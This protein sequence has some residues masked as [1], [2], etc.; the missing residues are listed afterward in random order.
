[1]NLSDFQTSDGLFTIAPFDHRG[2]L[3]KSLNL[4]L[5]DEKTKQIFLNLKTLF[6][7]ILS[8]HVSAV[9]TDPEYGLQTLGE[10]APDTGLFLSLEKSGYTDDHESMTEL[11]PNWGIDGV[12]KNNAGAKLLVYCNPGSATIQAKYDLIKKLSDEAKQKEVVF[13]VEPVLY[14]LPT[15]LPGGAWKEWDEAWIEA[16]LD[17]CQNI[18]PY[19]DILK[20][21]YPGSAEACASVTRMHPNWILLSRGVE[22]DDFARLLKDS[23]QH[24]CRGFA[25]GRAVW[26]ELTKIDPKGWEKFLEKTSVKRLVELTK[27]LRDNVPAH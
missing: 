9:L 6:M 20:V 27:I 8:P 10:K 24:G 1:M 16:H 25:A 17:V 18:A 26:Q 19:C 15:S 11:Y 21:Q 14:P 12:K 5:K 7:K 2:S 22:Y 23:V 4:D 13:L 3:A